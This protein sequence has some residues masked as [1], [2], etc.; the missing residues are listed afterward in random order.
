MNVVL[1]ASQLIA[2]SGSAQTGVVGTTLAGPL[3]VKVAASDGVGVA[4]T[5]VNFAVASGGGS[6]G[7]SSA[8]SDANGLAQTTFKLGTSTGVQSVTASAASLANSPTTFTDSAIAATATKLVVTTQPSN[9]LGGAAL[10]TFAVTAQDNNGNIATTFAG[11]V[12]VS[13]GANNAGG[14]LSGTLTANAVLG[15]ATF[16]GAKIN[17]NGS[18]YTLV[19]SATGLSSATT[20]AFDVAV[21]PAAVIALVSGDAQIA[22]AGST[23]P[24]PIVVKVTDLGSNGVAGTAV[25]FAPSSGSAAPTSV[26]T[27]SSGN[28]STAWTLGVLPGPQSLT[29]SAAG[30]GGSP[31]TVGPTAASAD[32][33]PAVSLSFGTNPTTAV[34]GVANSPAIVVRAL[35]AGSLVATTFTGNVT[36]A[37]GTNPGA[38]TLGGTITVAAV[39]GV[40]TFPN[41]TLDHVGVGYTLIASS[42]V[43]TPGTSSAFTITNAAAANLAITAGNAQ[44]A[45]INTAL[46][47]PLTVKVTDAFGNPVGGTGVIF[48]VTGGGGSVATTLANTD[49][50]GLATS[51]WTLG[52]TVGAQTATATSG[53]LTGSPAA[54][55][56]TGSIV[57]GGPAVSLTFTTSPSNAVAGVANSPSIVVQARD[58]SSLL[59]TTFVGNVTLTIGTNPGASALGG[60]LTVA[61][62]GG[63]ATFSN[64]NLNHS[65]VGYTLVASSGVLTPGTS[66]TF[67][68]TNAAA[69]NFAITAGQAQT[70]TV[71]AALPTP[72][73]VKVTDAFSNPVAGTF[74]TFAIATGGG[75]LGTSVVATDAAGQATSIWTLGPTPGAQ[76]VTTSSTGLTGSPAT[77]TATGTAS[78]VRTWTGAVSTNWNVAGNWAPS[79]VPVATDSVVIPFVTNQ[80]TIT[81]T[82]TIKALAIAPSAVLTFGCATL[83]INGSLD[84]TGGIVGCGG[85][86]LTSATAA[87]LK[88]I[89]STP[90]QVQG[91]YSLNGTWSSNSMQIISGSVDMGGNV[92]AIGAGGVSTAGTATISFTN[93]GSTL[94]TTGGASFGGG[95]ETGKLTAGTLS[96][97][98]SFSEG[99]GATDGFN[100]GAAF[101]L[102]LNGTVATNLSITDPATSPLGNLIINDAAGVTALSQ[103]IANN[104]TITAGAFN[105]IGATITGTLTD[106]LTHWNGGIISFTASTTPVSASTVAI[107]TA[108]GQ[109]T[110]NNN[111]SILAGSLTVQGGVNV[112]G[113]LQINGHTLSVNGAFATST[114]GQLTMNN[115]ADIVNVNGNA[116]F[117]STGVGGPM[118]AGTLNI[119]G[120]FLQSGNSQSISTSGTNTVNFNGAAVQSITFSSPDG[121][122]SAGCVAACFQNFTVNKTGGQLNVLTDVKVQG[123]FA[124]NSTFP[125]ITPVSNGP[126]IVAGN[127][128]YGQNMTIHR[129]GVGGT[130]SKGLGTAIDSVSYFGAAQTY[131][132]ATLGEG[133]SD[134][135]G[136]ANWTAAGTLTGQMVLSGAGQLN[137]SNSLAVITGNFTSNG[138]ST[139]KMT[140]NTTDTLFVGGIATFAGGATTGLLTT[141]NLIVSGTSINVTGLAIDASGT[142]TT[143]FN[144][145]I[146]TQTLGWTTAVANKGYNNLTL[147]GA[148]QRQFSGNQTVA[149]NMLITLGSGHVNGSWV[150][151]FGGSI[152]DQTATKDAWNGSSSIVFIAPPAVLPRTFGVNNITFT[153]GTVTLADSLKGVGNITVDGATSHLT[154]NGHY[155]L[156]TS[157]F[158]TQNGGVLEMTN[159]NDS[160]VVNGLSTFNGGNTSGLLTKGYMNI[161]SFTQGVNATAFVADSTLRTS[162]GQGTGTSIT[163]ANPGF[164]SSLSHFGEMMIGDGST[165]TLNSNVFVQGQITTVGGPQFPATSSNLLITAQGAN[166]TNLFLTNTRLLLVDGSAVTT[167]TNLKF[168]SM[169]PTVTQ[170]E[171]Q[172]SGTAITGD[173]AATLLTP[174]F[175]TAPT[176]GLYLK[177]TDTDGIAPFLTINVLSPTPL[178]SGGFTSALSGA[179]INGWS[180]VVT[181]TS[182]GN[183]NWSNPATWS[184]AVVPTGPSY[185]AVIASLHNVTVDVNSSVG[186]LTIN[187]SG[188]LT[189]PLTNTLTVSGS[190][191]NNGT[192]TCSGD[193]I[194]LSGAPSINAFWCGLRVTGTTTIAGGTS[195]SGPVNVQGTGIV[196]I[197]NNTLNATS[198]ATSGSGV[199]RMQGAAGQFNV[200]GPATFGGGNETGLL[201][202]GTLEVEGTFSGGTG[203]QFSASGS[204]ITQFGAT[205]PQLIG[206]TAPVAGVGFGNI[207]FNHDQDRT[208]TSN[209]YVG[210]TVTIVSTDTAH[211][212]FTSAGDT[213]TIAGAGISDGSISQS[214]WQAT[215]NYSGNPTQLPFFNGDAR[216]S[217]GGTVTLLFDLSMG[218]V[219]VDNGTNLNLG[220][221]KL[222]LGTNSFTTQNGGDPNDEYEP[223]RQSWSGQCVLQRRQHEHDADAG[224]HVAHRTVSGIQQLFRIDRRQRFSILAER[225]PS[226][227]SA[228]GRGGRVRKPRNGKFGIALLV[229]AKLQLERGRHAEDG[230]V[231]RQFV[232]GRCFVRRHVHFRRANGLAAPY[233]DKG[234]SEFGHRRD[235]LRWSQYSAE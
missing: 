60:T 49:I 69:A 133:Y 206:W 215:T 196:D 193:N 106:P 105:G 209:V 5:T 216:F 140:T 190:A 87:T 66:A 101:T 164:G 184:P 61:A 97:A 187:G 85:V 139:L 17:K 146:G 33:G 44:T 30:L 48:A 13:F 59:A 222:K 28:A 50:A 128:A 175:S 89:V 43:L 23:L 182:A 188:T 231:R 178:A 198:F 229:L 3:V 127:A 46:P 20:N 19:A 172:R 22:T 165:H 93:A 109:V 173:F 123:N 217:S 104:L 56:A 126:L 203:A 72:L 185:N 144:G 40:A 37:I 138:T 212:I 35:D 18:A 42:G 200:S 115:A 34:A 192:T 92:A 80:P 86:V 191:L 31:V 102:I 124:N 90:I 199:L 91:V 111:P 234:N 157:N 221:H 170:L 152:T 103:F 154:L 213:V 171:V 186:N 162:I 51:V 159:T 38:S 41:I 7:S 150:L 179:I 120:N 29:A 68:I 16:S 65:G 95:S 100:A 202:N 117:G 205:A 147:R 119:S 8:V 9:G 131:N 130:F 129:T 218:N 53:S 99:G 84:A 113:N 169:D 26:A 55:T 1:P 197:T 232:H 153:A 168:L 223:E 220:G 88:G 219:V 161:S 142:F 10:P 151:T 155:F 195:V 233:Y 4:G 122:Y 214:A 225:G 228:L 64:I 82:P 24:Q 208:F 63:V 194:V 143:I 156:L 116:T 77:F 78:S 58:A 73:T 45:T 235:E 108:G 230:R 227:L 136:T 12:S 27:N 62:V 176:S 81:I 83:T 15:V 74:V 76:S 145:T 226:N 207:K 52:A 135:R 141:G 132:P 39:A 158:T 96:V 2:Q 98:S 125:V 114:N 110:F 94:V 204:H 79:G 177:A 112:A 36:L 11:A 70:G 224:T 134:I 57:V 160:L 75:S 121:N 6:V 210:G 181:V 137:V 163:F 14:T 149:G 211:T 180:S 174:I 21:G 32:A 189:L 71:S 201:T 25:A 118:S 148:A 54:F 166:A 47:T 107:S 167:L 67:N 183:G